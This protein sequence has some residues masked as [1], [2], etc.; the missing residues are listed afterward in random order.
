MNKLLYWAMRPRI[1]I[2]LTLALA[3]VVAVAT[4]TPS[5][6]MPAAPGSDKLHHFLAFGALAFPMAFARPA[7]FLW[8]VMA[9]SAYGGLIELIQPFIGRH[10]DLRDAAANALGALA[11]GA[12]GALLRILMSRYRRAL[13]N[14]QG[15]SRSSK[16]KRSDKLLR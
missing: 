5:D 13:A 6:H 14:D 1:A 11:G 8:I 10:S 2:C 15:Y 9:V 7:A 12:S 3:L 16:M 4:L